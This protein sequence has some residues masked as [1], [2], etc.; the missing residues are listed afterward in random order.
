[1]PLEISNR[2]LREVISLLGP[3]ARCDQLPGVTRQV[4]YLGANICCF[5]GLVTSCEA[6]TSCQVVARVEICQVVTSCLFVTNV[7]AVTNCQAVT[8]CQAMT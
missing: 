1:M 7:L 3:V 5:I 8:G 2:N 6:V 4:L